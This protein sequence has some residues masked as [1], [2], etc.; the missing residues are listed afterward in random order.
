MRPGSEPR[1]S[2]CAIGNAGSAVPGSMEKLGCCSIQYLPGEWRPC[3]WVPKAREQLNAS[4]SRKRWGSERGG[5]WPLFCLGHT[6]TLP[7]SNDGKGNTH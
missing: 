6:H 4:N 3:S 7:I 1:Q 5:G 2:D